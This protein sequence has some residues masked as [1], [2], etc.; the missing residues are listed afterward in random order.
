MAIIGLLAALTAAP[1][2]AALVAVLH[3]S[4][5]GPLVQGQIVT[6]TYT[7]SNTGSVAVGVTIPLS[8][9][10]SN[11]PASPAVL[12]AGAM[13]I[14]TFTNTNNSGQGDIQNPVTIAAGASYTVKWFAQAN[15]VTTASLTCTGGWPAFATLK[16]RIIGAGDAHTA[17]G[18]KTGYIE[19]RNNIIRIEHRTTALVLVH[20]PAGGTCDITIYGSSGVALRRLGTVVLD[21]GGLGSIQFTADSDSFNSSN[22]RSGLVWVVAS[23]AVR[24]RKPVMLLDYSQRKDAR[25]AY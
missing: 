20:G 16:V 5:P 19:V 21:A 4:P 22:I 6:I 1:A 24:D 14:G 17:N 11:A 12:P 9:S 3:I 23:G 2:R 15:G 13:A 10:G 18:P 25:H 7:I 8:G